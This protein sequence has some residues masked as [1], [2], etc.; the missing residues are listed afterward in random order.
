MSIATQQ[1]ASAN[2]WLPSELARY[3]QPDR[4][5]WNETHQDIEVHGFAI[6]DATARQPEAHEY[7]GKGQELIWCGIY[8]EGRWLRPEEVLELA[9]AL[10]LVAL[11]HINRV[12]SQAA[13]ARGIHLALGGAA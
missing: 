11:A 10:R 9:D 4:G 3:A 2:A 8:G 1:G 12:F 7:E 5:H 13:E 6:N